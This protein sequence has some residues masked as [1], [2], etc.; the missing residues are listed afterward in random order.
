MSGWGSNQDDTFDPSDADDSVELGFD[1][2]EENL[3]W[4]ESDDEEEVAAFDPSR[5]LGIGLLMLAAL[6]VIVGAIWW[7]SNRGTG[8]GPEADG[9]LIAAPEEPFKTRPEDEG[10]KTF[11]GTGDTSFAVGEGQA[12]EGRLAE[13]GVAGAAGPETGDSAEDNTATQE[14]AAT[15]T[16]PVATPSAAPTRTASRRETAP[17]R[18]TAVQVGAFPTREAAQSGWNA[19]IRQTAVLSGVEYRIVRGQADIG[20][21]Y[22]LQ[23]AAGDNAS[24]NRLCNAL[25][26]DGLPCLVK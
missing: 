26:A 20:T 3:P 14:P 10:G 8:G 21:V 4:L 16:A 9:S 1:D 22:R 15:P 17:P 5:L 23:A 18:G 2:G 13:E 7:V 19:L 24:A 25:K 11:E 12:R 6:V